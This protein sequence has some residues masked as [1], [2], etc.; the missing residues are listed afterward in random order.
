MKRHAPVLQ[1]QLGAEE[2]EG[3]GL[4]LAL[5]TR[6]IEL[7]GGRIWVVAVASLTG[8]D[9]TM[10]PLALFHTFAS[11]GSITVLCLTTTGNA[12]DIGNIKIVA[13]K[14]SGGTDTAIPC[15]QN[16]TCH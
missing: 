5:S 7:H 13:I 11:N 9:S 1:T 16:L 14:L 2:R 10:M 15:P 4:G 6:L 12:F 8:L 3:T